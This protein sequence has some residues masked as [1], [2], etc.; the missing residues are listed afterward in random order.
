MASPAAKNI[1][2]I[3]TVGKLN[4]I[5]A[6]KPVNDKAFTLIELIVVISLISIVLAFA[7][8][9]LN[10]SFVTDHQ[11]KLSAWIVLTVKS[12]KE[13]ALREQVPY[14]LYLD[15]DNQQMWTAK[16][17]PAEEKNQEETAASE[18]TDEEKEI[19]QENKYSLPQGV[20]LMDVA[21][22][23][24]E[25]IKEGIVPIHFYPKGYSDKAIIHIQD[26]DDNRYSYLVESFLP[27]VKIFEEYIEF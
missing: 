14:I 15:F 18:K 4:K 24:D 1:I 13:N 21:F 19:P 3:S 9:K 7:L 25:K 8:P 27:H 16:D 12:L 11:R 26:A 6:S 22:T 2:R 17:A 23:D 20:R 5:S 10:I